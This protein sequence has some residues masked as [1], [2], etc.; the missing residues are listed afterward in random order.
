[1]RVLSHRL[2]PRHLFHL[3]PSGSTDPAGQGTPHSLSDLPDPSLHCPGTRPA[4]P[5]SQRA[6]SRPW[7]RHRTP[8]TPSSAPSIESPAPLSADGWSCPKITTPSQCKTLR[9]HPSWEDDPVAQAALGPIIANG[10][11]KASSNTSNGTIGNQSCSNPAAQYP[12]A[13]HPS[14]ALS[15]TP[16]SA[17]TCTR[18]GG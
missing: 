5:S 8:G 3:L 15:L 12:R 17:T 14:S 18:T 1:M 4:D 2:H 9:N 13:L 11:H 6:G 16:A 10:W 7:S